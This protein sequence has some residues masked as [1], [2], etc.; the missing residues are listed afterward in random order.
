MVLLKLTN[1]E[2]N[3]NAAE[4]AFVGVIL[5]YIDFLLQI[6][7]SFDTN[8]SEEESS[9]AKEEVKIRKFSAIKKELYNFISIHKEL[10]KLDN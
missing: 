9:E 10:Y 8:L 3:Q 6:Y 2:L 1:D 5:N 4:D 7:N